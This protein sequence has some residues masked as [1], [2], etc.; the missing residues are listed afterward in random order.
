[1]ITKSVYIIKNLITG[2]IY[3]G[4]SSN[5]S[6]RY[7]VHMKTLKGNRHKVEDMQADY[8]KFGADSFH[9]MI[10]GEFSDTR[11]QQ[12]EIF[13]SQVMRSKDRRFGYNYKDKTGTSKVMAETGWRYPSFYLS[14]PKKDQTKKRLEDLYN[15][16]VI[17]FSAFL[18]E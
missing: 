12:Q 17:P 9:M 11:A 6:W 7:K 10:Y 2:R 16:R 18:E 4:S 3:V 5:P 13:I 8:D 15:G 1:M 14:L